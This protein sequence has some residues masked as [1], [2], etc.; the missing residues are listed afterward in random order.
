MTRGL[1]A[2]RGA[3]YNRE[4]PRAP[5][6]A[7]APPPVPVEFRVL[8]EIGI[9]EQLSRNRFERVLPAGLS[10]AQFSVLN[11]FVRLGGTPSLVALARAFQVSK[12]A[13]GK[14]VRKL[15]EQGLV[16]V[17][18]DPD[19]ARGKRVSITDAG[20]ATHGAAIAALEPE[21]ARLRGAL[22]AA[23]FEALLPGLQRLRQWLDT[24]R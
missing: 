24:H 15:A 6:P 16:D 5:R 19:D 18:A 17:R 7:P 21:L 23:S 4:V 20:V 3:T 22:G 2:G 10:V 9:V 14:L 13:M 11:H 8:N 1:G 12:P